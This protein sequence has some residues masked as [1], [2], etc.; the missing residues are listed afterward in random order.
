MVGF[1]AKPPR[2]LHLNLLNFLFGMEGDGAASAGDAVSS[3]P[4]ID[5]T[6][7]SDLWL[8]G[9]T[10]RSAWLRHDQPVARLAGGPAASGFPSGAKNRRGALPLDPI[11][12]KPLKTLF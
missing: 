6:L 4:Y 8:A 9:W 2:L 7:E 1:G 10:A 12:G 5:G 3:D 11:K